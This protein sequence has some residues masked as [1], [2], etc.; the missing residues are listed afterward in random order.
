M[1]NSET[2][3]KFPLGSTALKHYAKGSIWWK[4]TTKILI[5]YYQN[6][7]LNENLISRKL[8]GKFHHNPVKGNQMDDDDADGDYV[9]ILKWTL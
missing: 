1:A 7:E 3:G 4:F 5:S 9:I 8:N 6:W 2:P